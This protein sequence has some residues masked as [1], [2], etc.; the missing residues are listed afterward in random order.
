M[1]SQHSSGKIAVAVAKP[2]VE[3]LWMHFLRN[4]RVAT[5]RILTGRCASRRLMTLMLF[6]AG[7][8]TPASSYAQSL[9][10]DLSD[11]AAFANVGKGLGTLPLISQTPGAEDATFHGDNSEV[12]SSRFY[13]GHVFRRWD[14]EGNALISPYLEATIGHSKANQTE[15]FGIGSDFARTDLR[16]RSRSY[17]LGIGASIPASPGL[18]ITPMVLAGRSRLKI[19][20]TFTG[21]G[22][23]GF[24]ELYDGL[25]NRAEI[26]STFVGAALKLDYRSMVIRDVWLTVTPRYNHYFSISDEVTNR[27]LRPRGSAGVGTIRAELETP[28]RIYVGEREFYVGVFGRGTALVGRKSNQFGFQRVGEIG[29]LIRLDYPVDAGVGVGVYGSLIKGSDVTGHTMGITLTFD[30]VGWGNRR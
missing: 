1:H 23:A 11:L 8:G 2:V 21:E 13:L 9:S 6:A 30:R 4:P 17:L 26:K 24:D 12:K 27:G 20:S 25:L 29:G 22:A 16:Y 19:N 18:R 5:K 7:A 14:A 3:P 15:E 28:T 10:E